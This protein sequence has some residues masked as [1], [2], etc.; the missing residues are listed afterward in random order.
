MTEGMQ[1]RSSD[2]RMYNPRSESS[3]MYRNNHEEDT[4]SP[5]DAKHRDERYEEKQKKKEKE[6]KER[7]KVKH[8]RI[9]PKDLPPSEDEDDDDDEGMYKPDKRNAEREISAITGPPGNGGFLTSLATQAKGPG[10]AGGNM[11]AMSEVMDDA[12]SSL[13]KSKEKKKAKKD[14]K[15]RSKKFRPSTGQF[16]TPPGGSMGPKGATERRR[17]SVRRA[18]SRGKL[19]GM[20]DA[21]KAVEME[22]RGVSVKQPLSKDP[23]RYR[24]Y[25]GTMEARKRLGGVRQDTSSQRRFGQRKYQAGPTG[26]GRL[27]G[28]V[29]VRKPRIH[30]PRMSHRVSMP[31]LNRPKTP[32]AGLSMGKMG[33]RQ[34]VMGPPPVTAIAPPAPMPSP[35]QQFQMSSDY[36]PYSDILKAKITASDVA[37]IRRMLFQIRR[38][39]K[40]KDKKSKSMGTKDTAGAGDDKP[41]SKNGG[42]KQTSR[43][44]GGTEDATDMTG[45]LPENRGG[46][47]A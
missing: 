21:P 26:G 44:Q 46:A 3:H 20:K 29:G 10:A 17:K 39:L 14:M 5:D 16:K 2:T 6:K 12:W 40:D 33:L 28:G 45:I 37:E 27:L 9:R 11:F 38:E 19:T 32:S 23:A 13:L 15:E 24:D 18:V 34:S 1:G 25:Q 36:V 7:D 41:K 42:F 31:H 4:Y 30:S 47:T 8:I 35:N 43:P 22:H